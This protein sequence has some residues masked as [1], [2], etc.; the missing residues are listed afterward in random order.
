MPLKGNEMLTAKVKFVP[1]ISSLASWFVQRPASLNVIFFKLLVHF[2][3]NMMYS[4]NFHIISRISESE[5]KHQQQ[6]MG[7]YNIIKNNI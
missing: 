6:K 2:K 3:V 5:N 4:F 1:C 7:K